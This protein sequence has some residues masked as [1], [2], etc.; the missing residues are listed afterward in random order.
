MVWLTWRQHRR[1]ALAGGVVLGVLATLLLLTH[2][3]MSSAMGE[4]MKSCGPQTTPEFCGPS[5]QTASQ[6]FNV[7]GLLKLVLMALPALVAI[8]VAAPMV[9]HEVEQRTHTFV[10]TQSVTRMYW[11]AVKVALIGVTTVTAALAVA[12]LA[13]WWW[14]PFDLMTS[15]GSWSFFDIFGLVPVAYAVF[16]LALGLSA[17][18]TIRRTVPAMA[19]TLF[20]FVIVR[21]SF[22][23][24]RPHYVPP[25]IKDS[26]SAQGDFPVGSLQ[27]DLYWTDATNHRVDPLSVYQ[28][29]E[30][31]FPGSVGPTTPSGATPIQG[32]VEQVQWLN[33]HGYHFITVYQPADRLWTF[34]GIE[35]AIFAVLAM[36][37]IGLSA[38]WL[39]QRVH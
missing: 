27:M 23:F 2:G 17:S 24:L 12:A 35:A 3:L 7:G 28:V 22:A 1:E 11:F 6:L 38:W 19:A 4:A 31:N 25:V 9:A 14:Q 36:L 5:A 15:N 33:A 30:Q 16:A 39:R 10:W 37:L 29:L 20:T 34:Q 32:S 26:A 18:V 13:G 8:F 21:I